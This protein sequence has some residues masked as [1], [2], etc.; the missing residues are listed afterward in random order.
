[1]NFRDESKK[2]PPKYPFDL[3]GLQ[4]VLKTMS[5]EMVDIKKQVA[6][7]SSKKYFRPFKRNSPANPKPPNVILHVE[8]DGEEDEVSTN[9]EQTDDEEVAELQ[10]MWDF[11]HPNEKHKKHC[12]F[13]LEVKALSICHKKI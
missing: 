9:E 12:Q 6:E 1:M 13:P 4:K 7:T 3:E 11:I 2:K 8:S 5:N 10:G